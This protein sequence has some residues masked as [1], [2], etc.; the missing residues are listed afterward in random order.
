M[1]HLHLN[2][3]KNVDLH[4]NFQNALSRLS[5][6]GISSSSTS[7][8]ATKAFRGALEIMGAGGQQGSLMPGFREHIWDQIDGASSGEHL[9]SDF[10][11]LA[12]TRPPRAS[13]RR[14]KGQ[15]EAAMLS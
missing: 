9:G 8:N 15:R 14:T 7:K 11:G 2:L 13:R 12:S 3:S 5:Q 6:E 1:D 10:H 4:P